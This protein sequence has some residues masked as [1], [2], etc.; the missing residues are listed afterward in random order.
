MAISAHAPHPANAK[1]WME[2]VYSDEGQLAFLGGFAHPIRFNALVAAGKVPDAVLKTLPPAA[3]YKDIKFA[4]L[5]QSD[6]AKKV[7]ADA[8]P[9]LVKV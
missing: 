9:R 1:L 5:A 4:S 7:I 2:Y 6:A 8:W 3:A